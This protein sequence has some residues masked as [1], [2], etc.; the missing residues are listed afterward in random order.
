MQAIPEST[1]L[2]YFFASSSSS[3]LT[4]IAEQVSQFSFPVRPLLSDFEKGV[5]HCILK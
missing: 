3:I 5:C 4:A 1:P 2:E